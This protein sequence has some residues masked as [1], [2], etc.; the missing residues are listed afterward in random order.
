MFS[1]FRPNIEIESVVDLT[2]ARLRGAG[3][4]ALLLDV[5]CTLKRYGSSELLV[6]V[7]DWLLCV[8]EA[9]IGL[10]L[11]SNG[12]NSRIR[13]LAEGIK[14]PFIAPAMKP[15]PFAI[16]RVMRLMNYDKKTTAMVGDQLFTDVLAGKF[17]GV[18]TILVKP[19]GENEEPFFAR[20]KRPF[21]KF[22]L[23]R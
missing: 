4:D 17:A 20:I 5:D 13:Q 15:L 12:K 16:W 7:S 11:V 19:Q 18:L 2:A 10:Y 3:I 14:I 6:G 8:R 21:E 23:K 22:F 9:G 1:L